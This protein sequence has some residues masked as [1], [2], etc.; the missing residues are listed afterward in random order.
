MVPVMCACDYNFVVDFGVE[1][2]A[3]LQCAGSFDKSKHINVCNKI[4]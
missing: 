3:Y 2:C 4:H 1:F